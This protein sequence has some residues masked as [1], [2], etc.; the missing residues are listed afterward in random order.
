[1]EEEEDL[2]ERGTPEF[3]REQVARLIGLASELTS[4]AARLELLDIARVFQKLADRASGN[5]THSQE[6]SGKKTA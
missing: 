1:V 2:A 5:M 4:P 6:V 3:Y